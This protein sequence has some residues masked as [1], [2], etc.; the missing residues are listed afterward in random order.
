MFPVIAMMMS[1]IIQLK[2]VN[3]FSEG[4][5]FFFDF[6]RILSI[7]KVS[8]ISPYSWN[9]PLGSPSVEASQ[10]GRI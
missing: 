6:F 2:T 3:I 10:E 8:L 4:E 7:A 5:A 1:I 9:I